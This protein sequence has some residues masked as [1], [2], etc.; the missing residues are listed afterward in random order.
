M[1]VCKRTFVR[2]LVEFRFRKV[3]NSHLCKRDGEVEEQPKVDHLD[4]RGLW[5]SIRYAD[6]PE[7]KRKEKKGK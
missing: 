1:Y 4:V 2:E 3:D 7:K 6:E 5:Q